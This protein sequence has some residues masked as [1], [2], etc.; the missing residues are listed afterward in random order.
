MNADIY[1]KLAKLKAQT[2]HCDRGY[3]T[4]NLSRIVKDIRAA[5]QKQNLC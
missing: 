5:F 4:V 2:H 3:E 1:S